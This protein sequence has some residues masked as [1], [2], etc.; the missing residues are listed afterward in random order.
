M[1]YADCRTESS[2]S[3]YK[4]V[5]RWVLIRISAGA[6]GSVCAPALGVE[7]LRR[8]AE[9]RTKRNCVDLKVRANK[10]HTST[11]LCA[12][13]TTIN[14]FSSATDLSLF[15]FTSPSVIKKRK[16]KKRLSIYLKLVKNF[17]YACLYKTNEKHCAAI[18]P[19]IKY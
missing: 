11:H 17:N 18:T 13:K 6:D 14:L 5:L 19:P 8:A 2:D 12:K 1:S 4:T 15:N 9:H 7:T 10:T 3:E 16:R